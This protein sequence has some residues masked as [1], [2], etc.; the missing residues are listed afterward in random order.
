MSGP[1][2][3][4][5]FALAL[6]LAVTLV[7]SAIAAPG[8]DD[9]PA[10]NP[11]LV[12]A[13]GIDI[14]VILDESGSVGSSA[15]DVRRAFRAFTSALNNT[16]SR[17]AVSEFSSVA[18]LPL[19]GAAASAYTVVT[20]ATQAAIF[21]PYI[22]NGYNPSGSTHWEDA[23]R[24]ARYF[25]PRPSTQPHLV[26]FITDGDP[27]RVVRN[28]EVT[29]S[30]GNPNVTQDE[31]ELKVPLFDSETS[32][33]GN[34]DAK[35]RAV[36]NANALKAE[37]SHILT[38]AVG[39]GVNNSSSLSRII[40]VSGP[41]VFSGTGTFNISTHDVYRV[42]DFSDLEDAMREAAFQLCAP[43]I[44]VRKLVD[45]TPDPGTDDAIPGEGWEMTATASPT[46]ARW[47][48]PSTGSGASASTTTDAGGFA[49]FQWDTAAPTSSDVTITE[50]DPEDVPPGFEND[51]GATSCTYRTPDQDDTALAV[52]ASDGSFSATVPN[53]SI[54]TCEMV[55]R[56]PPEPEIDIEKATN[57]ADADDPPGNFIAVGTAIDWSYEVTNT[58][59]VTLD[60]VLVV[61]DQGE[62]V[63]CPRDTLAPTETITCTAAGLALNTTYENLGTVTAVDPFGT[64]VTAS[65]P[66]H[67]VGATAGI[68]VEKATNGV[69]ADGGTGPF[70]PVGGAVTWSYVITNTGTTVLTGVTLVD[71]QLGTIPCGTGTLA[72]GGQATCSA[73][74]LAEPGQYEN[75]ATA[76]GVN[77]LGQTAADSDPS[78]YF[79]EDAS[80]DIEKSTNGVDADA[81]TGPIVEVGE[82]VEW[83]YRVT[84]TGNVPLTGFEV[85]DDRGVLARCPRLLVILVGETV[86]CSADGTAVAGQYANVGSVEATAPSGAVVDDADPSHYFGEQGAIDLEKFTNEVNADEPPGPF[87]PV[88]GAVT[89]RYQV[90][91]TGNGALSDVRVIDLRGVEVDCDETELAVGAS[92][93]CTASGVAESDEYTNFAGATGLTL[94]RT[95]VF[96]ADP[97]H[98]YGAVPG[99]N[100]EKSTNGVDADEPPGPFV[101]VGQPVEWTYLVRNTGN[102]ALTGVTVTDDRG[103]DVSCPETAL[104]PGA[105]MTCTATGT[106]ALGSYENT[107]TASGTD[108]LQQVVT[109][110]D[111]SHYFGTL[112]AIDVEK[113]TNGVDADDPT[114]PRVPA[115]SPVTWTYAVTNP[116]NV[117]IKELALVDDRGVV[118][119]FGGG[120]GDGDTDLDPGEVWSY[121][122]TGT[123]G[124]GQYVNTATVTGLDL[125]EDPVSD[126]DPSHYFADAPPLPGPFPPAPPPRP[127]PSPR[128]ELRLAKLAM[129]DRVPARELAGFRLRIRNVGDGTARRVRVCDRLPARLALYA[130]PGAEIDGRRACF[131]VRS[132]RPRRSRTFTVRARVRGVDDPRRVCNV[133]TRSARGVRMR[134]AT[135]C[136]RVLPS[137]AARGLCSA[138]G[139]RASGAGRYCFT[140]A[141]KPR[142]S[143]AASE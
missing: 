44:T 138:G 3:I 77:E 84:N 122:A 131:T 100:V 41:D 34:N 102:D 60:D 46:P 30:P 93:N 94:A 65:D 137:T 95:R 27:N 106:A 13:C 55:N 5:L 57:G 78:H 135:V 81:P 92:T 21:E 59:N 114:G 2:A 123:A 72:P 29:Y 76:T 14:H 75:L 45:F 130:A 28:S 12:T 74:G 43:S 88:G 58:G 128:P 103:E 56:R 73:S 9:T 47:V 105:E 35:D 141:T 1:R 32:D 50:E 119:Q 79:G 140:D 69:D 39:E 91:N 4:P 90:T 36:S 38:V 22:S 8:E 113:S 48:L 17:M 107:A 121:S 26:V 19:P 62:T 104:E 67:Y 97:S 33:S 7:G 139:A 23:F 116:G 24:V 18:R 49:S 132:L 111:P 61:D 89:W 115:G 127:S 136:I 82:P 20:D 64:E 118:P 83:I 99:I 86:V 124:P 125:L 53:D 109:D 80:I 126:S 70:V 11:D 42:V 10:A 85:S 87:V 15:G 120:D 143:A 133:A 134:R 98:Y 37:G 63:T 54:V 66:S 129:R 68:D 40:D 108:E 71:D 117:P 52:D 96:D 51:P 142:T 16:G 6:V 110:T 101:P 31:Y 112:S 25:L